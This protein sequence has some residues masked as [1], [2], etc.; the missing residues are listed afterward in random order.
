RAKKHYVIGN[1]S[2]SDKYSKALDF[3]NYQYEIVSG[4]TCFLEGMHQFYLLD[5]DK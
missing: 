2:L 5:L 3:Y 1:K 4:Q